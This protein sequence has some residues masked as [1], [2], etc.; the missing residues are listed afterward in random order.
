MVFGRHLIEGVQLLSGQS[1]R[2]DL[3]CLRPAA[4]APSTATLQVI[5]VV[6]FFC[7]IGPLADLILTHHTNIV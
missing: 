5:N 2:H 6:T 1:D 4:R 7:F 3:H